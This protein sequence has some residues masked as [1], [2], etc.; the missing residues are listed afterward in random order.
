MPEVRLQVLPPELQVNFRIAELDEA[1][2]S[3]RR[4]AITMILA[5]FTRILLR[6]LPMKGLSPTLR[7]P[8]GPGLQENRS[9]DP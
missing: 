3:D 7:Q 1:K 8:G 5:R 9:V 2:Q 4:R 6:R